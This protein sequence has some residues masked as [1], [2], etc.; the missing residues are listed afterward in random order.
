MSYKTIGRGV[1]MTNNQEKSLPY[2]GLYWVVED[3]QYLY[4][5][6]VKVWFRDGSIKIVDFNDRLF[7]QPVG[8]LFE[9]L[10]DIT[11]FNQVRFDEEASTIVFPNGADIA[12]EW[13]YEHG[14]EALSIEASTTGTHN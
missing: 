6:K 8:P 7:S 9:P 5:F 13:L 12:P 10:K 14:I 4:D 1:K 2:N 3:A 11:L